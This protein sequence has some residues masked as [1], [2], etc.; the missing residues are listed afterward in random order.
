MH[1]TAAALLA[2]PRTGKPLTLKIFSGDAGWVNEGVLQAANGDWFPIIDGLPVFPSA[3]LEVDL[4]VFA[5]RHQLPYAGG[6]GADH[7]GQAH[8]NEIGRAHL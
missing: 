6:Q 3:A 2:D 7:K 5:K 4:T 1:A 8:T